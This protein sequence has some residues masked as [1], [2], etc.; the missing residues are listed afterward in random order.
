LN[1]AFHYKVIG[2]AGGNRFAAKITT[3]ITTTQKT[4]N[5]F[6]IDAD[7]FIVPMSLSRNFKPFLCTL[8]FQ[9]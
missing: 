5:Y 6:V 8:F 3:A 7:T 2:P 4:V 9:V 1:V